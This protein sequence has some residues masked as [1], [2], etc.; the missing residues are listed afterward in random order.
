MEHSWK[1]S[2]LVVAWGVWG[3]FGLG[4]SPAPAMDVSPTGLNPMTARLNAGAGQPSEA[5]RAQFAQRMVPLLDEEESLLREKI[6]LIE[7]KKAQLTA[8]YDNAQAL[9][10]RERE[11]ALQRRVQN[12]GERKRRVLGLPARANAASRAVIGPSSSTPSLD[13]MPSFDP[14]ANELP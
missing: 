7:A 6:A 13:S 12:L 9:A 14:R 5:V 4:T 8:P 2:L 11:R 1:R 10:L 3:L